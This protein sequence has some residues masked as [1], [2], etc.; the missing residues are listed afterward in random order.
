MLDFLNGHVR[1]I[2]LIPSSWG[3]AARHV[4]TLQVQSHDGHADADQRFQLPMPLDLRT[5]D[6]VLLMLHEGRIVGVHNGSTGAQVNVL[7]EMGAFP[8]WRLKDFLQAGGIAA[9]AWLWLPDWVLPASLAW[10]I[11]AM[12]RRAWS[13]WCALEAVEASLADAAS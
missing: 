9:A 6:D 3:R 7:R 4:L 5:G 2:H 1:H 8:L 11:T 13:C 12:G 10:V